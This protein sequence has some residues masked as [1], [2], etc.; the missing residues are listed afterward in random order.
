[1]SSHVM[2]SSTSQNENTHNSDTCVSAAAPVG[3]KS[4]SARSKTQSSLL[5]YYDI[6]NDIEIGIDEAGRGPLFGRLY[7]AGVVLP[8][9]SNTF[10]YHVLKDSK[11]FHSHKKIKEVETYIKDNA[12]AWHVSFAEASEIDAINI[13]QAV[14]RHMRECCSVLLQK[15]E[16]WTVS[17]NNEIPNNK[18]VLLLVDGNDF[19]MYTRFD[20]EKQELVEIPA[21]TVEGGDN[22]YCSIAAASILAKVARDDYID[23]LCDEHPQLDEYYGLRK[24]KGYGTR[25]H[26]DGIKAHGISEWHRKSYGP[27]MNG[28]NTK[29]KK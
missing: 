15:Q 29:H 12:I 7:V 5:H 6:S 14:L 10:Q 16:A 25:A 19:P 26:L 20:E 28:G 3:K 13:R 18:K 24:N 8:K 23:K 21:M 1:M 2:L 11:K 4:S 27:C 17:G 9:S 22:T